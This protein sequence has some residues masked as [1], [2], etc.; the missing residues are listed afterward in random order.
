VHV[1]PECLRDVEAYIRRHAI[2]EVHGSDPR[3]RLVILIERE[4]AADVLAAI[5]ETKNREG[6]IAVNLVYQHA[7]EARALQEP[8]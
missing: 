1:R 7:E 6:V 5:D 4:S 3:G 2:A 8:L